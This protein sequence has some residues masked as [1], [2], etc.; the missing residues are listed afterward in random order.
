MRWRRARDL[1]AAA[2]GK[3][4]SYEFF[5]GLCSELGAVEEGLNTLRRAVARQPER[6]PALAT[7]GDALAREFRTD[8]AIELYWRAFDRAG[9]LDTRLG[10]VAKLTDLYL[11]RNQFDRLIARLEAAVRDAKEPREMTSCLAQAYQSSGDFGSARA[12]LERLLAASPRDTALL[13]QL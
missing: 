1:L 11:Q 2:P 8:E 12:E 6:R 13:A 3:P 10:H 4:E 7:L 5:A 9:D